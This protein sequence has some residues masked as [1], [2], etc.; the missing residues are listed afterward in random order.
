MDGVQALDVGQLEAVVVDAERRLVAGRR[1]VLV[2]L[3]RLEVFPV[4][5]YRGLLV[6][7]PYHTFR[8]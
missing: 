2:R 8:P 5:A 6:G 7:C 4:A 1:P 3:G